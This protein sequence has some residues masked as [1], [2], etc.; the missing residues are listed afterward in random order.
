MSKSQLNLNIFIQDNE[1]DISRNEL[2]MFC[3][4]NEAFMDPPSI[5]LGGS[6]IKIAKSKTPIKKDE[7][8]FTKLK[9]KSAI[10]KIHSLKTVVSKQET[11]AG[12]KEALVKPNNVYLNTKSK[13]LLK[14]KTPPPPPPKKGD[15]INPEKKYL[16]QESPLEETGNKQYL[17][18]V[19]ERQESVK[20]NEDVPKS[21]FDFLDNW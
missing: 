16:L 4:K 7:K 2:T 20:N 12:E 1:K 6:T 17:Q 9:N 18:M 11:K 5:V 10:L 8:L 15:Q 19:K 14:P 21:G 3:K 13:I